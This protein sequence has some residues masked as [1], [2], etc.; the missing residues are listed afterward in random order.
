[1]P[2]GVTDA[3]P[4]GVKET[5]AVGVKKMPDGVKRS[6]PGEAGG[7]GRCAGREAEQGREQKYIISQ[8]Q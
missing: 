6:V 2:K 3:L 8:D 7:E 4:V 5:V 1:M